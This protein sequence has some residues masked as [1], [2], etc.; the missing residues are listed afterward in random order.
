MTDHRYIKVILPLKLAWEP[1]YRIPADA[2]V[3]VGSRVRVPF[4]GRSYIAVA[5]EM[6]AVPDVD[7]ARIRMISGVEEHLGLIDVRELSL[8]R[9]IS[10]YYLCTVGEVYKLA[11]P[12]VRTA[13]E[14]TAANVILRQEARKA[15]EA[16]NLARRIDRLRERLA[17]KDEALANK[18]NDNVTARLAADRAR[19]ARELE[20]LLSVDAT[21]EVAASTDD[22]CGQLLPP[23]Q[24]SREAAEA[25]E[26]IAAGKAVLI[27]GGGQRIGIALEL[28]SS[29]LS[30]GHDVLFLVPDIKLAKHLQEKLSMHFGSFLRLVH[31]EESAA[32]RRDTAALLRQNV[33]GRGHKPTLV[34][35][36]RS[37][38]FLPYRNLGLVIIGDEHDYA[39]KQDSAP[40]YNCRDTAVVLGGLH[41]AGVILTSP[42]PSLESLLNCRSGRYLSVQVPSS[43]MDIKVIDTTVERKK[44][45]MA[46]SLSR[47]LMEAINESLKRGGKVLLL[48]PWGPVEDLGE[49]LAGHWP[50]AFGDGRIAVMSTFDARRAD[51]SDVSLLCM[52]NA[53]TMLGRQDFRADERALQTL[54]Q[55]R[56][57]LSGLM[58]VQTRQGSHQVFSRNTDT[59]ELLLAERKLFNYPPFTRMVDVIVRDSN[60]ARLELLSSALAGIL[61]EWHPIGPYTPVKGYAPAEGTRHIRIIL[62]RNSSLRANKKKIADTVSDFEESRKYLGHI[63]LD[64]D[65][66]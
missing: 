22:W 48:R 61:A 8:W 24:P 46:G 31:S 33:P 13:G 49:E 12:A 14:E 40:R 28:I 53:E 59:A 66:V 18:H 37:A 9:F 23:A 56:S 65:P 60:E 34:L 27:S 35:G 36:T 63:L 26:G 52:V 17:R 21:P 10:D 5:S 57:R 55:L 19:I 51:I 64:V 42:T 50:D 32:R 29:C 4:A 45:G 39:Y 44:N 16:E 30:K 20:A 62:P 2:A 47:K 54:E 7:P 6:D 43:E 15:R 38:L 25:A 41:S 58:I 3:C 1:L 11:Y